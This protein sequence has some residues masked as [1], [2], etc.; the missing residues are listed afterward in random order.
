MTMNDTIAAK[1]QLLTEGKITVSQYIGQAI[2]WCCKSNSQKLAR[3]FDG[4]ARSEAIEE[5]EKLDDTV[6]KLRIPFLSFFEEFLLIII[7]K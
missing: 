5:F 7:K 2:F 3:I 6:T 4:V 1:K